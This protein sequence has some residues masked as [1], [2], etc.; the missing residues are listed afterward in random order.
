[1]GLIIAIISG[2]LVSIQGVFNTEVTK[3]TNIWVSAS[4]VQFTALF[5]CL[6]AWFVTGRGS[7]F[8]ALFKIDNKYMLLGG[9]MGA[10]ITYTVIKSIDS[11][12]A[13][14]AV[15]L[16]VISQLIIAYGIELFGVFGV[17]R[18]KFEWRKLIGITLIIGGI[19]TFKWD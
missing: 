4:F 8:G 3:E 7:S 9:A 2:A 5:V 19:I 11:L 16:I 10:F 17:E 12:G 15:M 13:A 1:M 18:V 6:T 14:R